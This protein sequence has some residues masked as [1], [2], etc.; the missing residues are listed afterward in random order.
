MRAM[1]IVE[2]SSPPGRPVQQFIIGLVAAT[3]AGLAA[4]GLASAGGPSENPA[5]NDATGYG[6]A[7]HIANF[8]DGFNGIGHLRS[9]LTGEQVS[10]AVGVRTSTDQTVD[11]QGRFDPISNNG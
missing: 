1:P 6:V 5:T 8:N 3:A 11:T 9:S 2:T 7:N 10:G 4:P